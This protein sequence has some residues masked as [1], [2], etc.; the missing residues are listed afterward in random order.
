MILMYLKVNEAFASIP[1]AWL[2]D[3]GVDIDKLNKTVVLL[4][5]VTQ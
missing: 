5:S 1:I 3:T 4:P 2:K